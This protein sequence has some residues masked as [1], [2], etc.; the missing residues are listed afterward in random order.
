MSPKLPNSSISQLHS[1]H[2]IGFQLNIVPSLKWLLS[3][4]SI[5]KQVFPSISVLTYHSTVVQLN[6]AQQSRKSLAPYTILQPH[7]SETNFNHSFAHDG[8]SLWNGL[9]HDIRTASS[10]HS[11][12]CK[13]TYSVK[14]THH[15]LSSLSGCFLGYDPF[16]VHHIC[17]LSLGLLRLRICCY[18]D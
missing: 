6:Q 3:Y 1:N 7:T 2:C 15:S 13:L 4:I 9:P 11:F 5:Y 10:L 14:H 16:S 18:E 17:L 8:P 12:R